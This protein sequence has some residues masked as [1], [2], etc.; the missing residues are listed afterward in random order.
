MYRYSMLLGL[1]L[2]MAAGVMAPL[3]ANKARVD[4]AMLTKIASRVEAR[5]GVIAIEA[6]A[7]V[8]Y[9]A[10]QPD[11]KTFVVEL[12]DVVTFGF[13]DA[14]TADP[15]HPVASV[16]VENGQ[17]SDGG[18]EQVS[19]ECREALGCR[20]LLRGREQ[21][22]QVVHARVRLGRHGGDAGLG[23]QFLGRCD[24]RALVGARL[25]GEEG[26][27]YAGGVLEA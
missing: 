27:V 12:R 13:H 22:V 7:P 5:T 24:C 6:S 3:G 23:G 20:V 26:D 9:V 1:C 8:P 11:P 10:S 14:F 25:E 18:S 15:R 4:Q 17:A 2:A 19:D 16:R 21:R